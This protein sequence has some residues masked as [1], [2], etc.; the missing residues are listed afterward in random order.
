MKP[1]GVV[2]AA[3]LLWPASVAG[4][5]LSVEAFTGW[6]G[7]NRNLAS[8]NPEYV[9]SARHGALESGPLV[10][11][12]ATADLPDPIPQLRLSVRYLLGS[13]LLLKEPTAT[14]SLGPASMVTT[15]L[16][17][18]FVAVQ[19]GPFTAHVALGGGVIRY[20][21]PAIEDPELSPLFEDGAISPAVS[22]ALGASYAVGPFQVTADVADVIST[23]DSPP[24]S[25]QASPGET[26]DIDEVQHDFHVTLG[27]RLGILP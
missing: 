8:P 17:A 24:V 15:L 14:R 2:L 21:F 23:F 18:R 6:F 3:F 27:F 5:G 11:I 22:V 4:Q 20:D 9:L 26:V 1:L 10:G 16:E 25:S 13:D 19:A 7:P 12:G